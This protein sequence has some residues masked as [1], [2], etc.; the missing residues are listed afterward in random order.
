MKK[1]THSEEQSRPHKANDTT[2]PLTKTA[3][4]LAV[5]LAGASLNRFEAERIGDHCL[6]STVSALANNHGLLFDRKQERVPNHW[7]KDCTV[8]RYQLPDSQHEWGHRV[9]LKLT[10]ANNDSE[11]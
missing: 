11:E 9:L 10:R 6:H 3:R 8:T 4:I 7:G 2:K 5:F 1:A